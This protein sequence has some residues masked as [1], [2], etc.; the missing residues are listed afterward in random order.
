MHYVA[1]FDVSVDA[2]RNVLPFLEPGV[3]FLAAGSILLFKP[4]WFERILHCRIKHLRVLHWLY[5]VFALI[6][7]TG[8]GIIVTG[9]A[10][11]TTDLINHCNT[12]EGPVEHFHP[13]PPDGHDRE[14]FDVDGVNFSYSDYDVT[15]AFNNTQS[16]GGPIREG[17][18]VRICYWGGEIL[19]LET[20]QR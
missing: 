14:R 9:E 7:T 8:A 19:R 18:P 20:V 10:F 11:L 3:D 1:V 17:L 15:A 13:M 6:Y 16:H 2:Y 12:I 4:E 5:F